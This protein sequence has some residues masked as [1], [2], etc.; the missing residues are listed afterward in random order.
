MMSFSIEEIQKFLPQYLSATTFDQ[1]K[2]ELKDYPDNIDSRM[3]TTYIEPNIVYQG[4]GLRDMPVV[5]VSANHRTHIQ[6]L[7]SIILSN[8]CDIDLANTRFFSASI[9]FAPIISLD[10]YRKTLLECGIDEKKIDAHIAV[11]KTQ[12][13]TQIFYLPASPA[14]QESIVFL[15]R[16][17]H[18]NNHDVDR[19]ELSEKR[20]FSLSQYGFYMLLFKLSIHFCRMQEGV[21]RNVA[22][23]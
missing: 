13:C 3:Y 9:M 20:I 8:T 22:I 18:S 11:I 6:Y 23:K 7:P 19:K 1:L 15:D 5:R 16:V 10:K 2:Q 21:D 14:M 4:D 17:C 12:Q